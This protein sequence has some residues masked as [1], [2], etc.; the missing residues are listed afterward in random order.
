MYTLCGAVVKYMHRLKRKTV[1][2]S[3]INPT[4]LVEVTG[5]FKT[6]ENI[7]ETNDLRF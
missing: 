5:K 7:K 4:K 3:P 2:A 1:D 6:T